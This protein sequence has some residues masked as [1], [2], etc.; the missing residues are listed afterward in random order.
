MSENP[1]K[2]KISKPY[3]LEKNVEAA[4]SYLLFFISGLMILQNEKSDKFI[5][6]HAFQSIYF[7]LF[8]LVAVGMINYIPLIG[9]VL[10][11]L[12][13][14]VFFFTWLILIYA[15]YYHKELKVPFIGDIA[16]ERV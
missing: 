10:R 1:A 5:R 9:G 13:S 2:E 16:K 3:K 8:F 11:E 6:F 4:C 12:F 7:S 15:A 14:F